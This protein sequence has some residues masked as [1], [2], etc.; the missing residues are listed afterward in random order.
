[1]MKQLSEST[2]VGSTVSI[3]LEEFEQESLQRTRRFYQ[4]V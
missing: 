1:M 2:R 3:T 4:D